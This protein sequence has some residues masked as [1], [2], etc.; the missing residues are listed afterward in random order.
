[1]KAYRIII[2]NSYMIN[3]F[4]LFQNLPIRSKILTTSSYYFANLKFPLPD[5]GEKIKE[6]TVKKL[7]VKEGD[8]VE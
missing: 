5:L 6:G 4:K 1:M 8:V 2:N 7:Y 3:T